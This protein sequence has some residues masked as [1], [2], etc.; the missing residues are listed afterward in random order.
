[1]LQAFYKGVM[2]VSLQYEVLF[3][4][5]CLLVCICPEKVGLGLSGNKFL[6]VCPAKSNPQAA[7][8]AVGE[9]PQRDWTRNGLYSWAYHRH[10]SRCK[11]MGRSGEGVR[12]EA[13]AVGQ[14]VGSLHA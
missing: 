9:V 6:C 10:E 7:V 11:K 14:K 4:K 3:L 12:I 2:S 8:A 5:C 13:R 1:M